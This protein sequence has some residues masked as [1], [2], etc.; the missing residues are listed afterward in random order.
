MATKREKEQA[1]KELKRLIE[2][3]GVYGLCKGTYAQNQKGKA[4]SL[5]DPGAKKF[6]YFGARSRVNSLHN[7]CSS[8]L[9][10]SAMKKAC[11]EAISEWNDRRSTTKS[12]LIQKLTEAIEIVD[13]F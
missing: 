13:T 9:A 5:F 2:F 1:K 10:Y 8:Y 11:G 3:F 7:D 6:C 4:V 12:K